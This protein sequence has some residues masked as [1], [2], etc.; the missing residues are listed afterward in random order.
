MV[1]CV[2]FRRRRLVGGG[3]NDGGSFSVGAPRLMMINIDCY[4]AKLKI[5]RNQGKKLKHFHFL[6]ETTLTRD[7]QTGGIQP[8]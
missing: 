6:T 4:K 8:E 2:V 5:R 7:K 1:V 3:G